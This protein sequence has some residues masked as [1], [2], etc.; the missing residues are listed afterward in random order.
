MEWLDGNTSNESFAVSI[1]PPSYWPDLID[2]VVIVT[3]DKKEISTT[4]GMK[5]MR[6]SPFYQTRLRGMK[7]KIRLCKE[8]LKTKDLEKL[9]ELSEAEALEMHAVMISQRPA[10]L[11]WTKGTLHLMKSVQK[12]RY[13]GLP[14]YFTINTGQ[15]VHILT[16]KDHE[17][18]IQEKLK[19]IEDVNRIIINSPSDGAHTLKTH[20]F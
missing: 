18:E 6:K 2:I 14:C 20:L 8:A 11:Y 9:G 4:E 10:L 5:G 16:T 17:K 19:N 1:Y 3:T 7:D 13:G 12:W 15:N